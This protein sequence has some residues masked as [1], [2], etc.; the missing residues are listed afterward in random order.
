MRTSRSGYLMAMLAGLAIVGASTGG[1]VAATSHHEQTMAL[2]AGAGATPAG[3]PTVGDSGPAI[4]VPKTLE[5]GAA[6]A[7]TSAPTTTTP[8]ASAP[9]GGGPA[10]TNSGP[11]AAVGSTTK[12]SSDKAT[13]ATPAAPAAPVTK[14]AP[15]AKPATAHRFKDGTY[16]A[17]GSYNSPGGTEKLGVTLTLASDKVA[18][19][20]LELLGGVGLSHTFQTNWASGYSSQVIG[21]DISSLSLGAISGSSLTSLGFNDAVKQIELQAPVRQ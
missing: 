1:V 11:G 20:T 17:T 3:E 4:A 16:S 19:S 9:T 2:A 5:T 6:A 14:A 15:A 10:V 13:P 8:G 18:K 12:P 7:T 21:K